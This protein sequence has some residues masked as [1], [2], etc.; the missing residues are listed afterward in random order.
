[1]KMLENRLHHL[2]FVNTAWL[3]FEEGNNILH[4]FWLFLLRRKTYS[5][6]L[7]LLPSKTT[8][9]QTSLI[10]Y[11]PSFHQVSSSSIYNLHQ[12]ITRMPRRGGEATVLM[13]ED[14]FHPIF[15]FTNIFSLYLPFNF[16]WL[17]GMIQLQPLQESISSSFS[18][19][20]DATII[21]HDVECKR[22]NFMQILLVCYANE[23][24]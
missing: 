22:E 3:L 21:D 5:K 6:T 14:K 17:C 4:T 10:H 9:H 15:D 19:M 20:S 12:N 8:T 13:L 7:Q 2:T 18:R 11:Q 1:M 16:L 24:S 23:N